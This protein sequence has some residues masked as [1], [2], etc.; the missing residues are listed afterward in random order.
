MAPAATS[1]PALA[2][3]RSLRERAPDVRVPLARWSPRPRSQHRAR[4]RAIELDRLWLRSLR[5]VDVSVHTLARPAPPGRV[6]SRR[7]WRCWLR[8]RPDVDLHDRRLRRD[9][10]A[11]RGRGA[12][13]PDA[14]VGG[15]PACAGRSVRATA[16]LASA[17][18]VSF[19]ET[20]ARLPGKRFVTGTP[21]RVLRRPR[22]GV[23]AARAR[24]AG[25]PAGAAR[26]RRLAG[27]PAAEPR[28]RRRAADA[29][30][31]GRTCC[32]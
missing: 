5:T 29:R 19:A 2:V 11:R 12:A 30:R 25:R 28:R 13:H 6:R 31:D 15:Q 20:C 22:P 1:I 3:A 27:G 21:I 4:P 8:R 26:L 32:T 9:P 10:G 18:A 14:A 24:P 16:R 23:G 7:R 17:L